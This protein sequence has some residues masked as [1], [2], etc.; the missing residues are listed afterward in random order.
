MS[1]VIDSLRQNIVSSNLLMKYLIEAGPS[2]NM[3]DVFMRC[4]TW[5]SNQIDDNVMEIKTENEMSAVDYLLQNNTISFFIAYTKLGKKLSILK[6]TQ[7]LKKNI[8]S[9]KSKN[10]YT[11]LEKK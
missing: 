6:L 4:L 1:S 3:I 11:C 2:S 5:N 10:T 7:I 9:E 8:G